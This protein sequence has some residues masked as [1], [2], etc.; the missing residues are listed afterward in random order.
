VRAAR[1]ALHGVQSRLAL[2]AAPIAEHEAGAALLALGI[3]VEGAVRRSYLDGLSLQARNLGLAT[4]I[5]IQRLRDEA[6]AAQYV[7]SDGPPLLLLNGWTA[8]GLVWPGAWLDR[9]RQHY[10]V[11]RVDHRGTG[12]SRRAPSPFTIADLADDA[13]AVLRASV[14]EPTLVLGYSMGGMVAQELAVRQPDLDSGLVLVG[15]RPPTPAH[16]PADRAALAAAMPPPAAGQAV[17]DHLRATWARLAAPG[18]ADANPQVM[19][20]LVG[21]ILRRPTPHPCVIAQVRAIA[22]WH[23]PALCDRIAVPTVVVH[24]TLDPLTPVGNGM[25][26]ARLIPD[27]DY[28]ELPGVGHLVVHEAGDALIDVLARIR[29]R[30]A[31]NR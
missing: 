23:G 4:R 11:I 20:E 6:G 12:W 25:R 3:R 24:G 18:F 13:A 16:L 31:I 21:Q 29:T 7:E 8:S 30:P 14:A 28:V 9:L 2:A 22:A 27:A 5:E 26:L 1:N 10:R 17:A 19:E 15:T